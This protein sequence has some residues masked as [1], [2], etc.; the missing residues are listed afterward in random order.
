MMSEKCSATGANSMNPGQLNCVISTSETSIVV[1][2][3]STAH[4]IGA[5]MNRSGSAS[6]R[7]VGEYSRPTS[8]PSASCSLTG[9]FQP[10]SVPSVR[11]PASAA[12]RSGREAPP[13]ARS[14]GLRVGRALCAP[15]ARSVLP[16]AARAL[17]PVRCPCWLRALPA[18]RFRLVR[19]RHVRL[20]LRVACAFR[21]ASAMIV[22]RGTRAPSASA[23]WA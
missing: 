16:E 7:I 9:W 3:P 14:P 23:S 4:I 22:P 19:G 21:I 6:G 15:R 8:L 17:V 11:V 20:A 18:P 5:R 2:S 10:P 13:R 1:M 12:A